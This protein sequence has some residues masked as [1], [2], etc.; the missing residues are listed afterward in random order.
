MGDLTKFRIPFFHGKM[1]FLVWRSYVEDLLVQQEIDDALERTRTTSVEEGKWVAM[2]KKAVSTIRLA[3]TPE[4]KYNYLKETDHGV[5]LEKLPV[6]YASKSLTNTLC[7]RWEL[8][9]FVKEDD[10]T[11]RTISTNSTNWCAKIVE[12]R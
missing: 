10:T 11:M 4:I 7:L 8:S 12:C 5:L 1:I 2:R 3:I 6:V 9:Q